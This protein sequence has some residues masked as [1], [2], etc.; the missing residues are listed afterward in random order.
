MTEEEIKHSILIVEDDIRLIKVFTLIFQRA[1]YDVRTAENGEDA[2]EMFSKKKPDLVILD[3]ILPGISGVEVLK[4]MKQ[5]DMDIPV[6][7]CSGS[8]DIP[9]GIQTMKFG[10][11]DYILK[12]FDAEKML[13]MV[14]DILVA[15]KSEMVLKK[16]GKKTKIRKG[17]KKDRKPG[18]KN[19]LPAVL[20]V[21][22]IT[23]IGLVVLLLVKSGVFE[24]SEEGIYFSMPYAHPTALTLKNDG[25]IWI[26]D[27][28]G[29]SVYRHKIGE[30]SLPLIK[31]YNIPNSNFTGLAFGREYLWSCDI[32]EKKLYV[33]NIDESLSVIKD[34]DSPGTSPSGLYYDN[35]NLWSCDNDE[36]AIYKH[37]MDDK[38]SVIGKYDSPGPNPVGLFGDENNIYSADADT[39]KIYKH[40][41]DERLSVAETYKLDIFPFKIAGVTF[42]GKYIWISIEDEAKIYRYNL[43]KLQ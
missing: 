30:D 8:S 20:S 35:K 36:R 5:V 4:K 2:L 27:W 37:E 10:A 12:P 6:I 31:A 14:K 23:L 18:Q 42:D 39:G 9:L 7:I 26:S 1:G 17:A 19:L 21:A 28:F 22:G 34:Y 43:S 29:Q 33:H 41:I 40:K 16:K 38:L 13:K 24:K 32:L 11:F 3:L 15:P 25:Y